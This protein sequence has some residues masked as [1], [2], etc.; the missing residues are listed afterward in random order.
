MIKRIGLMVVFILVFALGIWGMIMLQG[1][2]LPEKAV[3]QSEPV[4]QVA[5]DKYNEDKV[6]TYSIDDLQS[7]CSAD[8]Q[9]FCAVERSVKCTISPDLDGCDKGSV[10]GFVLGKSD[11]VERPT[12]ISFKLVKIKP[13]PESSDVSVYTESECN[14]KW[15]GL[16]Q[17]T[18]VYSLTMKNEQWVVTNIFA[19]E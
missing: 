5:Q 15:F 17:G 12:E 10:P 18:V 8:D 16:C 14:A 3:I 9:I 7:G 19:M 6:Y 1:R 4:S 13:I 11:D 2:K